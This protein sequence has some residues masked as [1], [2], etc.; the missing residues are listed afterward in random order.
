MGYYIKIN[1][2]IHSPAG[3][4]VGNFVAAISGMEGLLARKGPAAPQ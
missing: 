2:T 1:V 3:E 4:S